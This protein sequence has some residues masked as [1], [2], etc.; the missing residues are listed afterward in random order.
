VPVYW[1]DTNVFVSAKNSYYPFARVPKFWALLSSKITDG[2]ICCPKFVYDELLA[3][4]DDLSEW[5]KLRRD[6]GLCVRPTKEIQGQFNI[7]ADHVFSKYPRYKAEEFLTGA[8]AWVIAYALHTKGAVVTQESSSRKKKV[9]IPEVCHH[10][11]VFCID[12]FAMLDKLEA[13]F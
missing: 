3:G 1:L 11:G 9:R 2:N 8:D 4:K 12:T 10:F 13:V 7:I 5:V 6:K